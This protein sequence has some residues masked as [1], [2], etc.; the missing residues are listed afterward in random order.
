[1]GRDTR[2]TQ[3]STASFTVVTLVCPLEGF[4]RALSMTVFPIAF[5]PDVPRIHAASLAV[6]GCTLPVVVAVLWCGGA[7]VRRTASDL[8]IILSALCPLFLPLHI[9]SF[10]RLL[11]AYYT[12]CWLLLVP[13]PIKTLP[14]GSQA[15][16]E[17]C[18]SHD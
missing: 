15:K 9:I 18:G 12:L 3:N 17:K 4:R 5:Y 7:A 11:T 2:C 14:I 13:S 10:L 6:P 1:M 8:R 16:N